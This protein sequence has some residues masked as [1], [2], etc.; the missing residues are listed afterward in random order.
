MS[1]Y[2]YIHL[3]NGDHIFTELHFP[4]E[5]TGFFKLKKPLK[6]TMKEDENHVHF[7]FMPWIPFSDDEEVPLQAKSVVTM[8]NLSDEYKEMYKKGLQHHTKLED[9]IEF[10]DSELPNVLIN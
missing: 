9:V 3:T 6:L 10:E 8:A 1:T 5:K 4:K 2:K 7:G